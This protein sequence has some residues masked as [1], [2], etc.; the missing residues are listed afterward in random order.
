MNG[1]L[2]TWDVDSRN[3]SLC[4]RLSRFFFGYE[5]MNEIMKNGK[6]YRYPGFV[7][8]D[9]VRYVGQSVLFVTA[10]SL[11][12]LRFFL[13]SNGIDHVVGIASIGPIMHS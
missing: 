11:G 10:V 13:S 7:E 6:T 3:S 1:Y 9:D 5:I 4:G 2:V 12:E 8:R